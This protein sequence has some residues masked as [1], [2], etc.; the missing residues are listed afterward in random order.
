MKTE[1][2]AK[3]KTFYLGSHQ[4]IIL[5]SKNLRSRGITCGPRCS[6]CGAEEESINNVLF[7]CPLVLQIWVLSKIP[8]APGFFPSSSFFSNI[9]Y[10][11]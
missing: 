7:E 6:L 3:V 10:L 8:S 1:M 2:F 11:F 9:D 4:G 5:V